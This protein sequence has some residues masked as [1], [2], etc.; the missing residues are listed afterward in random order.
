MVSGEVRSMT[1]NTNGKFRSHFQ[2]IVDVWTKKR[3]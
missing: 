3:A 2:K 1:E